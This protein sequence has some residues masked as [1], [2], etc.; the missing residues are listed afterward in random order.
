M[1]FRSL[2][3]VLAITL[4]AATLPRPALA[5]TAPDLETAKMHYR[6]AEQAMTEGRYAGAAAEYIAAYEITQDAVL[7]YK[8]AIAHEKAGDCK[9]AVIYYRRYLAQGKPNGE[10]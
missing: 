10:F 3:A 4:S 1:R 6:N 9:A 7:F 5:Q 8:I 2:S